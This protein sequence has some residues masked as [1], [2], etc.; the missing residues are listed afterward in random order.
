LRLDVHA[1]GDDPGRSRPVIRIFGA[2]EIVDGERVLGPRDLGGVRPKQLLEILLA[3]RGH[4]VPVDR[5]ADLIWDAQPPDDIAASI[6]T[7]VSVLRRRL[8]P[9]RAHARQLV[10]TGA[11]AYRF[12]TD[13]VDLDLDR[14]DELLE[15]SAREPTRIARQSLEQALSL[16]RGD[17]LEDEPYALWAQDLRGSYQGRMLGARLDAADAA[18]AELDFAAAL[19]HAEAAVALDRFSERGQRAQMLTL[20]A[21]R[22]THEALARYR[23]YRTLLDEELGLEPS[24][25]TRALEGAVIR[26]EDIRSLLPRPIERTHA[27]TN[28]GAVRL[29]GRRAELDTLMGALMRGVDDSVTLIQIEGTT[30]VG[31]TRLLDELQA[32]LDGAR[33]GRASCSLHERNLNY[34]PLAAALREALADIDLDTGRLPALQRILPELALDAPK[35][36]VDEIEVLEALVALL[37]GHG[38]VVLLL[39]DL[40]LAD[41]RTLAALGYL[42]RRAAFAGAIVTTARPTG[43]SPGHPPHRLDADARLQLEPLSYD[44]LAAEGIADLHESTG[45]DPRLVAE[46]LACGHDASPSK[47]LTDALLAQCRAEGD[48]AYR[49]LIAASVLEQPFEP[50]PLADLL[51]AEAADLVEELERLCERRILR[52][53]GLRFRFRNDLVRQVLLESISPARQQ[54]LRQSLESDAAPAAALPTPSY[55]IGLQAG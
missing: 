8:V 15:R 25:E 49:V 39:D 17:V 55:A 38:P 26:Q 41:H 12:A 53:D 51:G 13:A 16:V 7:F 9:D 35:P 4:L 37:G 24:V 52:I 34:V 21:L 28:T 47:T 10:V 32:R 23:S 54:L 20:Y 43:T 19:A 6:Q 30:G 36:T 46:A 33:I 22:R 45:G 5:I 48:W 18:L 31:K 2:L 44:D 50:Q 1:F 3:A 29:V 11:E 40:H 14:F 27:D 42:R